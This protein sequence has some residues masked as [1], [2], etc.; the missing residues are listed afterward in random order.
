MS[1]PFRFVAKVSIVQIYFI[2][3]SIFQKL[4]QAIYTFADTVIF[5]TEI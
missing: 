2:I 1:I 4:C 3:F 5:L